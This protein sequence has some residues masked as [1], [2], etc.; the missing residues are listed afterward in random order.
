MKGFDYK[1]LKVGDVARTRYGTGTVVQGSEEIFI[2]F[3]DGSGCSVHEA[4]AKMIE[5]PADE[6]PYNPR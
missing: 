6:I 3:S 4:T 5:G 1:T 2:M